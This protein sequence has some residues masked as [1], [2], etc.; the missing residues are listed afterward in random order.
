MR[1]LSVRVRLTLAHTIAFGILLYVWSVALYRVASARLYSQ[2]DG[3]LEERSVNLRPLFN[4]TRGEV[5][6]ALEKKKLEESSYLVAHAVYD[7]QG[8]FLDGSGLADVLLFP[9]SDVG[10]RA[11][12]KRGPEWETFFLPNG[13]QVRALNTPITGSDGQ[14]YLFRVGMLLDQAKEEL[15]QLALALTLL[16]PL[17]LL[18]GAAAGWWM[19]GQ[20]LRP[21][22]EITKTG[23]KIT[24]SNL[25]ERLRLRG[26]GDELDQLSATLNDMIGRLQA[27]FEQM[28]QFISNV[29]H[30]LRT[31]LAAVR[32]NSEIAL[33]TGRTEAE[34]RAALAGNIEELDRLGRT[35]SDLLALARAEAGQMPLDRKL[36]N[37]A[38]LVQDA[39]ESTRVLAG[40]RG[41]SLDCKVDGDSVAE[42]D[43]QYLLRLL[44]NLIDNAIKYNRA[45][46]RVEVSLGRT[47]SGVVISIADTGAGIPKEELP[48]IF[49]RFFRGRAEGEGRASGAGLGLSLAH[50]VARAHGGRMEVE[51]QL[52][53]GTTFRVWLPRNAA[54]APVPMTAKSTSAR[55][56]AAAWSAGESSTT[57]GDRAGARAEVQRPMEWRKPMEKHVVRWSYWIGVACGIVALIWRGLVALG[58]PERF[59]YGDRAVGYEGFLNG[60][61]LFLL[62]ATAT[63]SYASATGPRT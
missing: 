11:L 53:Q 35:V 9:F 6:W 39:V 19:A 40:E 27:S 4:V 5:S 23:Q 17:V 62:I 1:G 28:S 12:A 7:D 8:H 15:R 51:T 42:V 37:L 56:D 33:R 20:T 16:V 44:V 60:A 22:A 61:F 54:G 58:G 45:N 34:Y 3:Q 25:N 29:S 59:I 2:I 46:G 55:A 38:E 36:E 21:V 63:A 10:R 52:G 47:D 31:P 30:E 18:V 49:D 26:T 14:V 24:A 13:H 43:A 41:I 48:R 32:G 50:W 57:P